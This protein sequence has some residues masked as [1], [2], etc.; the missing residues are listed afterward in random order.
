MYDVSEGKITLNGIDIRKYEYQEYL[1][2]FAAVFQDFSLFSFSIK[3]N[4]AGCTEVDEKRVWETLERAGMDARIKK[5]KDGIDTLLFH[6]MGDGVDISGGEAQKL[7]IA[8]ALYKDAPFVI[9]DEPTAA[10]D[11]VSEYEI[12]SHFDEMV[13]DKTS[14]YISHRMSS[15][16]FCDDILVFD[17]GELIQRGNHE[18][19]LKEERKVYAQLWNAQAK[20]YQEYG[21]KE[22]ELNLSASYL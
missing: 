4:V 19:L 16:R 11:P 1:N 3:E 17:A 15:C 21:E 12:Y 7:A 6:Q 13:K 2:L 22:E 9:L 8:R 10:L 5:M 20:Y 18:Q 14:I